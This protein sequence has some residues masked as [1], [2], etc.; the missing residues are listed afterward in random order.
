MVAQGDLDVLRFVWQSHC[1]P[2]QQDHTTTSPPATE[3]EETKGQNNNN[4][5]NLLTA[6]DS[7]VWDLLLRMVHPV[8]DR[9]YGEHTTSHDKGGKVV[10]DSTSGSSN[11]S[12]H[13]DS[14]MLPPDETWEAWVDH[15]AL[16]RVQQLRAQVRAKAMSVHEKRQKVLSTV[17]DL[18]AKQQQH[19]T[20]LSTK[21]TSI[22]ALDPSVQQ[23]CT[24]KVQQTQQ[25]VEHLVQEMQ[26][27]QVK[28]PTVVQRFHETLSTV[29]N[30]E[31]TRT[32][33]R[34]IIGSNDDV[35]MLEQDNEENKAPVEDR[36]LRFLLTH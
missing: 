5:D 19:A 3:R 15:S 7:A 24:E 35:F 17:E 20:S 13:D 16:E 6:V 21:T 32:A 18:L 29:Q 22:P 9:V 10:K 28:I 33:D 12:T 36:L 11:S 34:A 4:N 2:P 1:P 31:R 30:E 26:D 27:L 14:S 8:S 25:Q 23:V